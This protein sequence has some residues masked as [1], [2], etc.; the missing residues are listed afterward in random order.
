MILPTHDLPPEQSLIVIGGE[1][2]ALLRDGPASVSSLWVGMRDK[3]GR[4]EPLGFDRFSLALTFLFTIGAINM[5]SG[6]IVL[7]NSGGR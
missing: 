6:N 4:P 3:P 1:V 2:L 7:A 5:V